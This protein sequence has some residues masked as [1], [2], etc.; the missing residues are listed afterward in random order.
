MSI[1]AHDLCLS[2]EEYLEFED[3]SKEKHEYVAGR[4]FLMVGANSAHNA[5]VSNF[6]RL[7]YDPVKLAGCRSYISDMKVKVEPLQSFYYPDLVVTCEIFHPKAA[8][9]S[10]PSLII[11][12]LSPST[13]NVDRREKL[14]AYRS[15]SSLTEYVLVDQDKVRVEVYRKDDLGNW[16]CHEFREGATVPIS[17]VPGDTIQLSLH[18]I[19]YGI[20]L[21][22]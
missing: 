2:M 19:Y 14:L 11:E 12:V 15:I 20:S 9:I 21:G 3:S 4:I 16:H 17:S 8:Y 10:A 7:I 5:I 1:P 6:H 22:A 13:M 18:D